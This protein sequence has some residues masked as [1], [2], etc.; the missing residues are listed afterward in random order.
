MEINRQIMIILIKAVV[1][2]V[3]LTKVFD[4][5]SFAF[6]LNRD[7]KWKFDVDIPTVV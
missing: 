7:R 4:F 1:C 2:C 6:R 3:H 5:D